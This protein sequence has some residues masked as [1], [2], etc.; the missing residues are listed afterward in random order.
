MKTF[1]VWLLSAVLLGS[2]AACGGGHDDHSTQRPFGVAGIMEGIWNGNLHSNLNGGDTGMF[3][4]VT[5]DGA[6]SLITNDCQ[7]ISANIAANGPFFSGAGTTYLQTNCDGTDVTLVSPTAS[8]GP[9][10]PFQIVGQF[11]DRTGT[12]FANYTTADDSGTIS[13]LNFYPDYFNEPGTLPR[14]AGAY[15]FT[16]TLTAL[17]IDV[18]GIL[19]YRDAA[20]QAFPGTLFVIDPTVD[21]YGMTLQVGSQTLT[22]LAT[23]VDDGSGRDNDF[24]FAVADGNLAYSAVLKRD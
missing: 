20:G 9:V 3:V 2:V 6:L 13:F 18:N 19:S 5:A 1:W 12:A 14:A 23:L 17:S 21:A 4:I 24:L 7:Q 22:G 8:A 11:D 15:S 10:Q 16:Q